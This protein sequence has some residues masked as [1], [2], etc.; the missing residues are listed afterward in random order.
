MLAGIL[1]SNT[2]TGSDAELDAAFVAPVSITSNTVATVSDTKSLKRY[3][4]SQVAQRW[5]IEAG[6]LERDKHATMAAMFFSGI[7][8]KMYLRVPQPYRADNDYGIGNVTAT[9]TKG[10]DT[11]KIGGTLYPGTFIQFSNHSKVYMVV[12][13]NNSDVT[14]TPRLVADVSVGTV[15]TGK[16]VTMPVWLDTTNA[17]LTFK[18]EDG[19]RRETGSYKF[20]EAL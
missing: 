9:A 8:K 10:A 18:F 1:K 4:S 15:K 3:V 16:L 20:V 13:K 12:S 19:I 17:S 14:I 5:E 2:N 7:T 11:V 6:L